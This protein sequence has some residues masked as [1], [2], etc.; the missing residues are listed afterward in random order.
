MNGGE[1][2]IT[3]EISQRRGDTEKQRERERGRK[4]VVVLRTPKNS[5]REAQKNR[6]EEEEL[7]LGQNP[8]INFSLSLLVRSFHFL[9][10]MSGC[11][12]S[13]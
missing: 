3:T 10:V 4:T 13:H 9:T 11:C 7:I 12:S 1:R 8:R 6:E 2:Y 5:R